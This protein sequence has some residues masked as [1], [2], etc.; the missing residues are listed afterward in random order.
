MPSS[1]SERWKDAEGFHSFLGRRS[2]HGW[3]TP[4]FEACAADNRVHKRICEDGAN[5]SAHRRVDTVVAGTSGVQ[6]PLFTLV[7]VAAFRDPT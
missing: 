7:V 1:V 4:M 6:N 5:A 2:S 3:G